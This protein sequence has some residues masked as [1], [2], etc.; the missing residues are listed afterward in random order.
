M[1]PVTGVAKARAAEC[2]NRGP[3]PTF[4]AQRGR[5]RALCSHRGMPESA[6]RPLRPPVGRSPGA[7][8]AMRHPRH[9]AAGACRSGVRRWANRWR[10]PGGRRSPSACSAGICFVQSYVQLPSKQL[11]QEQQEGLERQADAATPRPSPCPHGAPWPSPAL[12]CQSQTPGAWDEGGAVCGWIAGTAGAGRVLCCSSESFYSLPLAQHEIWRQPEFDPPPKSRFHQARPP[13]T[14]SSR[15]SGTHWNT[16][17]PQG[18]APAKTRHPK[19]HAQASRCAPACTGRPLRP[20]GI[21]GL[22]CL[23]LLPL[24]R[25]SCLSETLHPQAGV[26]RRRVVSS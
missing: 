16:L 9:P 25:Q 8:T 5:C 3:H 4:R 7:P 17:W 26:K 11:Q 10:Q 24:P 14:A 20:R 1:A 19:G 12:L 15:A 6:P 2:F 22:L 13:S 21:G 23:Y 18:A